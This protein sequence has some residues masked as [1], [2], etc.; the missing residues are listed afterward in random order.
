MADIAPITSYVAPDEPCYE[1]GE[2]NKVL[3]IAGAGEHRIQMVQVIRG[4]RVWEYRRDLGPASDFTCPPFI[5]KG[6]VPLGNG[7]YD[8]L[9]TVERLQDLADDLRADGIGIPTKHEQIGRASCRER[10]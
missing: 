10:V 1:L 9:E 4:D 2:T 5:L 7:R 8:I 3:P 6:A